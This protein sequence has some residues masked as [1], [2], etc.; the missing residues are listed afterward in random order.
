MTGMKLR[1]LITK[2]VELEH[3]YGGDRPVHLL[4]YDG[5]KYSTEQRVIA[6]GMQPAFWCLAD[7]GVTDRILLYTENAKP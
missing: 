2:L 7:G 3:H 6:V 1:D 5:N 4:A